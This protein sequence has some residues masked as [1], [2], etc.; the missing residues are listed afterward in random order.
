MQARRRAGRRTC[1][2]QPF[3]HGVF[4]FPGAI[5][6]RFHP[7]ASGADRTIAPV[8]T[9]IKYQI[10][11]GRM[12]TDHHAAGHIWRQLFGWRDPGKPVGEA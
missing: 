1:V 2:R 7:L 10:A 12:N 8:T 4:A 11:L 9:D 6:T 3:G 5:P